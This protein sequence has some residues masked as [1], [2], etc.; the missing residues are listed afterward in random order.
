MLQFYAYLQYAFKLIW[1][2]QYR[3]LVLLFEIEMIYIKYLHCFIGGFMS[4]LFWVNIVDSTTSVVVNIFTLETSIVMVL[5]FS[6]SENS[7]FF[8]S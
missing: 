4:L 7:G 5:Y 1:H 8:S 6:K 3:Q 2:L